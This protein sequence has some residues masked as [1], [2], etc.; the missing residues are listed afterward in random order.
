VLVGCLFLL[1]LSAVEHYARWLKL[2]PPVWMLLAGVGYGLA[3]G[4][5]DWPLPVLEL[6]PELTMYVFLPLLLFSSARRLRLRDLKEVGPEAG[7]LATVGLGGSAA[8]LAVGVMWLFD[9]SYPAA[10]LFA[11]AISATDP[12]A[13]TAI[14][15]RFTA[16]RRL[17]TL[18]EAESMLNDGTTIV[19]FSVA[20]AVVFGR[21]SFVAAHPVA[22][23]VAVMLGGAAVGAAT[24]AAGH[25]LIRH[26]HELHDRF[27]GILIPLATVFLTFLLAEWMLHVSGVIAVM[28]ATLVLRKLHE[29][30]AGDDGAETDGGD[31]GADGGEVFFD[32]FWA[33]TST[34][35]NGLL[36]FGLGT[37]IGEHRWVLWWWAAPAA[38]AM[39]LAARAA[40]V[41][42]GS[43]LLSPTRWRLR[44]DWQHLLNISGLKGAVTIALLLTLPAD[45]AHRPT[46]V[47]AA[48]ALVLFTMVVHP[49]IARWFLRRAE[50]GGSPA[51][52]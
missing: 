48:F 31:A 19:L 36:F 33:F 27:I 50:L 39:L 6:G 11:I 12:L 47:C 16:P 24:G 51:Q 8:L 23:F 40:A 13:I 3:V 18:V 28:A 22:G 26:W 44:A 29:R 34:L 42:G 35:A 1:L 41:Y 45:Y 37:M 43:A 46:F 14:F 25:L 20:G 38:I 21:E 15:E 17:E 7:V 30:E 52:R 5:T 32:R 2:P 9:V 10:F 49:L 4:R